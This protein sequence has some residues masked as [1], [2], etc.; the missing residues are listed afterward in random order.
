M[1]KTTLLA[2]LMSVLI[3]IFAQPVLASSL[4]SPLTDTVNSGIINTKMLGDSVLSNT[5]IDAT[6]V[7]GIAIFSGTVS[8]KAQINELIRIARSVSGIKGVNVSKVK[9]NYNR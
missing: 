9:V 3:A 5:E 6:V 4:V 1:N 8:A 7:D 2:A